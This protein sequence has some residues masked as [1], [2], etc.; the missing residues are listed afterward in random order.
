MCDTRLSYLCDSLAFVCRNQSRSWSMET[1]STPLVHN[2]LIQFKEDNPNFEMDWT[3][4]DAADY[5]CPSTRVR[6]IV[7]NPG[8]VHHL[9]Q[10]PVGRISVSNAFRLAGVERLPAEFIK[11]NT[12][13]RSGRPCVRH[14]SKACHTQTASHPLMWCTADGQTVRCLNVQET[15]IIM[16]FPAEWMLPTSSRAAIKALG[17]AVPPSLSHA[18]MRAAKACAADTDSD[19]DAA[20]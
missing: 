4:V 5:G 11:N 8:L 1:V 16:G 19:C 12:K 14:V 7:G 6:I 2:C 10:V 20:F 18:I 3:V 17:N 15:A 9:R 13:T